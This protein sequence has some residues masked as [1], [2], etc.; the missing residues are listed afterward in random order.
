MEIKAQPRSVLQERLGLSDEEFDRLVHYGA[1]EVLTPPGSEEQMVPEYALNHLIRQG[2]AALL[3]EYERPQVEYEWNEDIA[4][5]LDRH[6]EIGELMEQFLRYIS[7]NT[8]GHHFAPRKWSLR[9]GA[10]GQYFSLVP[11]SRGLKL[12][13]TRE[14]KEETKFIKSR[15]DFPAA[16]EWI[17][18]RSEPWPMKGSPQKVKERTLE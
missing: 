2:I 16:L 10:G 7:D 8:L 1:V 14:K 6:P 13:V 17:R 4:A 11:T 12:W 5:L 18:T 15:A 3:R 9:I